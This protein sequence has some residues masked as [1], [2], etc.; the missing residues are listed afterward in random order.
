MSKEIFTRI[1]GDRDFKNFYT[2]SSL[3][4]ILDPALQQ[5]KKILSWKLRSKLYIYIGKSREYTSNISLTLDSSTNYISS[6]FHIAHNNEFQIISHNGS[7]KLPP[8]QKEIF[9]INYY[10][11]D[12]NFIT[13]LNATIDLKKVFLNVNLKN[14]PTISSALERAS[15]NDDNIEIITASEG[16]SDITCALVLEGDTQSNKN[17]IFTIS[18][19]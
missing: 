8:N 18:Q 11:N 10:S 16:A 3:A 19:I 6:N 7:N 14:N 15:N 12:L 2:F 9:T 13:S 17:T 4:C 5:E 1:K